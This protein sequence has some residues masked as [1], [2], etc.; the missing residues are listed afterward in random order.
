MIE[1]TSRTAT[2]IGRRIGLLAVV[3]CALVAC[4]PAVAS[5]STVFVSNEPVKGPFNS[6]ASPGYKGIQEA[7]STNPPKTTIHVCAGEY[8]EQVRIEKADTVAADAGAKLLLPAS[9]ANSTTSCDVQEPTKDE[10]QDLMTICGAGKVKISGLTLEG[11][12]AEV[13]CAKDFN[14]I[15]VGGSSNL[16]LTGAKILHAGVD[17]LIGPSGGCQQGIGLQIGRN[18]IGQV[19]TATLSSDLIEGY[20]KNGIT[21]DGPGSKAKV[22]GLTVKSEPT[23]E[24]ARN[25]IQVSRGATAKISS[26]TIEGN[27]CNAGSCGGNKGFSPFQEEED[28]TGILFYLAGSGSSV[29][30]S[31]INVND[32]G[33][34][35]LLRGS[36]SAKTSLTGNSLSGNRYWGVALDQGSAT[37]SNNTISGPGLVGI[38]IVQYDEAHQGLETAPGQEFGAKGTGKNDAISGMTAC[39]LEGLSDNG[40]NDPFASLTITK[41]LSKFSG[42]ATEICN[43]NTTSK[44]LISLT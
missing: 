42:N 39:A 29:K 3:A 44:L 35:N 23:S 5:A 22:Q 12:W 11:R 41:S 24:I 37:V 20:Q 13:N 43:N 7:V 34:Y 38:Q 8:K 17:P 40:P 9:P 10:Q 33:I 14:D 15:M 1:E 21:I 31:T 4:V 19:G 32:I 27:E 2:G 28:A 16:T 36:E 6:C 25:G 30:N 26:S 18:K